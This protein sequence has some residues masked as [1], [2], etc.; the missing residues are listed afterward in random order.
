MI[1]KNNF[2]TLYYLDIII[3]K[4]NK[5]EE[6]QP[7]IE[8]AERELENFEDEQNDE[9]NSEEYQQFVKDVYQQ[10]LLDIVN[11][12]YSSEE[13][14]IKSPITEKASQTPDEQSDAQSFQ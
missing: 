5:A 11:E 9:V 12:G 13:E 2:K 4:A 8:I 6:F 7:L 1:L 14:E 10:T 3:P